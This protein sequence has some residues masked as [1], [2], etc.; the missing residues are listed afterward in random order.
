M[1]TVA[2]LYNPQ[3]GS[4]QSGADAVTAE[5]LTT[6]LTGHGITATVR[7]FEAATVA[8][9]VRALLAE[10]PDAVLVAGGDGTVRAVAEH[11]L[12]TDVPLGV[13]PMGTMNV[14]ARDLG[15]PNQLDAAIAALVVA[16]VRKIDVAWVND[17]MFL[18]SSAL[19]MV[20][21]LGRIREHTRGDSLWPLTQSWARGV[22]LW[23]RY[24]RMRLRLR[25]D[26]K[27]HHVHTRA[28]V[29]SNNPL[30]AG[31]A[32]PMP[33]RNRLDTGQLAAY[34]TRDHTRWDLVGLAAR[35][36]RRGWQT[37]PRLRVYQGQRIAVDSTRL[38]VMSVMSDGEIT[39]LPVPL[40]YEIERQALPVLV[41]EPPT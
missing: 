40:R 33:G 30:D 27:E 4:R 32:V 15:V 7:E 38:R 34:V 35:M 20:P 19:A 11:I 2:I 31:P 8:E 17:R 41:P 6:L 29:V 23:R 37:D 28:I 39:Q 26:G 10:Q 22:R 36:L 16:P 9:D 12:R 18:C 1:R 5:G 25:I 3:A 13:L 21:H 14:L 24:P